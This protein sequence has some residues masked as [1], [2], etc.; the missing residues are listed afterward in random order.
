[1]GT[2]GELKVWNIYEEGKR[3]N[4]EQREALDAYEK[5][6]ENVASNL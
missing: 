5:K 2:V 4:K 3:E 6:R 1:M